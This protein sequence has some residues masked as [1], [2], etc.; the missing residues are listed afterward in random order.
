M[1]D[2]SAPLEI[3]RSYLLRAMP[4]LPPGA[5]VRTVRI[6][7]GYLPDDGR[8]GLEGRLREVIDDAG[9]CRHVHTIKH[10]VGLVRTEVE[11]AITAEEFN[12]HWP[13]T[14]GR[15]LAKTRYSVREGE[16]TWEIDVFDSIDLVLAEVELPSADTVVELPP[17]LRP[18]VVR[19]V[20]D[21]PA[22][23]NAQIALSIHRRSTSSGGELEQ[24]P[25][26][27]PPEPPEP[28]APRDPTPQH[29]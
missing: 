21:E 18:V 22:Y 3:E 26:R 7:Q 6:R 10:G 29:E 24:S 23:R 28:P 5:Q 12:R 9:E 17:W 25:P 27:S 15:R 16:R 19:E 1:S 4:Q 11:R 14:E 8:A 20:T 13:S 2:G